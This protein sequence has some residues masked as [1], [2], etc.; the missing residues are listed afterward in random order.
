MTAFG[1]LVLMIY[2]YI[3][4]N[5]FTAVSKRKIQSQ[6]ELV[7]CFCEVVEPSGGRFAT[8]TE[9]ARGEGRAMRVVSEEGWKK[10]F[11]LSG[12]IRFEWI[13]ENQVCCSCRNL[14]WGRR[15]GKNNG[16]FQE[17][18]YFFT[19]TLT[20]LHPPDFP[21]DT[22][23][24]SSSL[25]VLNQGR[26]VSRGWPLCNSLFPLL[27]PCWPARLSFFFMLEANPRYTIEKT[28]DVVLCV[29]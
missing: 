9:E 27:L 8:G 2:F 25:Q 16:Y 7:N 14:R 4:C 29:L 15:D 3:V 22:A 20:A 26:V 21:T 11:S 10:N 24:V 5:A 23:E 12:S 1:L 13:L 6:A 18:L 17:E 19:A 28:T